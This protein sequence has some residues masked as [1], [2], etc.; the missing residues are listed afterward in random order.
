M[1][2][3][4]RLYYDHFRKIG[5]S[6]ALKKTAFEIRRRMILPAYLKGFPD[7]L[8]IEISNICNMTCEYCLLRS[9]S[10][11]EKVMSLEMFELLKP[12]VKYVRGI[13]LSG[14]AE[15][16]LNKNAINILLE[17]KRL[18]PQCQVNVL[19]NATLLTEKLCED[20]VDAKLDCFGFSLD[21]TDPELID[22]IR[23]GG[24]LT[25]IIAN[26][27]MLNGIKERRRLP[28]PVLYATTVLQSK[29]YHQLPNI[30]KLTADLGIERLDVNGLEPYTLDM[31]GNE[32]WSSLKLYKELIAIL[33]DSK[34]AAK[35][36]NV[37]LRLASLIPRKASCHEVKKPVVLANGDVVPCAVLAYS[38]N[39]FFTIDENGRIN[40]EDGTTEKKCFGNIRD[41]SIDEI[42]FSAGY[43]SFREQVLKGEYPRPCTNCLVKCGIIC[44]REALSVQELIAQIETLPKTEL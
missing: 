28:Y 35:A 30:I 23:K 41:K 18:S 3:R 44:V 40:R 22:N 10:S 14:L 7:T 15:P 33:D 4:L 20:L 29:N 42:W 34:L 36:N 43:V 13:S 37:N 1:S 27:R 31:L 12:F 25:G 8:H 9:S 17:I 26:I 16:F 6:S 2:N 19:S 39:Y 38:R 21:G 5:F 24:S 32:L 11:R